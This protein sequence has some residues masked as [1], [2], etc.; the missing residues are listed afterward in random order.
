[1]TEI[2][3]HDYFGNDP[4][5]IRDPAPWF[6]AARAHGPVWQEP[7]KG[8]FIVT[9]HEEYIQVATDTDN[10]SNLVVS[11]GPFTGVSFDAE[12]QDDITELLDEKRA[13]IPL[14]N[15]LIT[16]D[17]PKHTDHR[18]LLRRLL[19]PRR[20]AENEAFMLRCA[21]ELIDG[22]IADGKVEFNRQFAGP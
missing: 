4:D 17:P 1:M 16:F 19:T 9:G 13:D 3:D 7:H 11:F 2:L 14:N 21:H 5:L 20:V 18:G 6:E 8:V 10:F 15:M 22:W 12:G